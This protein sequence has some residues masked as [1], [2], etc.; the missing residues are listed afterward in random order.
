MIT[1]KT[2][3]NIFGNYINVGSLLFYYFRTNKKSLFIQFYSL[4][5]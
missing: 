3:K 4:F 5:I 2:I 1:I